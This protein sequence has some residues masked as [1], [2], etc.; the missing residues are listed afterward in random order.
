MWSDANPDH[1]WQDTRKVAAHLFSANGLKAKMQCSFVAHGNQLVKLLEPKA[2]SGEIVDIQ[3]MFQDFTFE[4]ICDIAFGVNP[5]SL[6]AGLERGEKIDFL[7]RFDRAQQNCGLRFLFPRP[8]WQLMR[9]LNIGTERVLREDCYKLNEYVT[10][11]IH[12]RYK[13]GDFEMN[14]D[15]LSMYVKTGKSS[16]KDYMMNTDYLVDAVLNFMIAGRDTTSSALTNLFK[17]LN[18]RVEEKMIQELDRVVGRGYDVTWDHV[19]DLP[20]SGAVFNEV[21]RLYPPVGADL[22]ICVEDDTFPSGMEAK[23]GD[24]IG[25]TNIAIGRDPNLWSEP[26]EFIPER[27]IQEGKPTRRPDEYVFPVFWG[28]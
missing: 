12:D 24:M 6:E 17:L 4:T 9:F 3:A 5:G 19:R 11:I 27:W 14:D 2:E 28:G 10:N 21:L 22:R 1:Q 23:A 18:P 20:Y 15:L 13:S 7:V 8:M 16:G 25:M 26:N